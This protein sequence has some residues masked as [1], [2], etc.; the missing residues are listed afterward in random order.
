MCTSVKDRARKSWIRKGGRACF[1]TREIHDDFFIF[2]FFLNSN[3]P[4]QCHRGPRRTCFTHR[5]KC[6]SATDSSPAKT[7]EK[8]LKKFNRGKKEATHARDRLHI[9]SS[10]R[11]S[12]SSFS[13]NIQSAQISV[14]RRSMFVCPVPRGSGHLSPSLRATQRNAPQ[15][16][17]RDGE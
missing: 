16:D 11:Q 4:K 12:S 15:R 5:T 8:H 17:G 2:F 13:N 3:D 1:P 6:P 9:P 14:L 10:A 7:K